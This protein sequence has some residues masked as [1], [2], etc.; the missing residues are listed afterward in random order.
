MA[1]FTHTSIGPRRSS[2]SA[3]GALD[4]VGVGH[5]AGHHERLAA[6]LAHLCAAAS[7]PARPRAIRPSRAPWPAKARAVAR[8][9][10]ADAPVT[11]MTLPAREGLTTPRYPAPRGIA[12]APS[13]RRSTG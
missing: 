11:T 5:V 10:P 6:A 13:P 1:T 2:T 4:G 12:H 7:R 3:G 8:P 9:T